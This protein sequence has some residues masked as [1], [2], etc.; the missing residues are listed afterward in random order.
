[1]LL[2]LDELQKTLLHY[3][4]ETNETSLGSKQAWSRTFDQN[5]GVETQTIETEIRRRGEK[6]TTEIWDHVPVE[7][8]LTPYQ[9][10]LEIVERYPAKRWLDLGSG[11][12]RLG[13]V[14]GALTPHSKCWGFE[15]VPERVRASNLRFL[16]YEFQNSVCETRDLLDESQSWPE[17][18]NYFVYDFAQVPELRRLLSRFRDRHSQG[19]QFKLIARGQALRELIRKQA[20]WL[21]FD[22]SPQH[23]ETYSVFSVGSR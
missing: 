10:L 6:F 18:D 5:T 17:A 1:M 2:R 4:S 15:I 16:H 9:E 12:G 11:Y 19:K 8:F 13:V 3:A 7:T 14:V 20:P 21:C 22:D 23:F